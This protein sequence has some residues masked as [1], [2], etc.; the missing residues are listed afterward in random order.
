MTIE[1]MAKEARAYIKLRWELR[2]NP[3]HRARI[4]QALRVL[5][6]EKSH[7]DPSRCFRRYRP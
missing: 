6:A 1:E 4:K 7:A 5:A 2:R 3:T